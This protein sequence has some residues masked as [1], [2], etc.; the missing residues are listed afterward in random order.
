[1][2]RFITEHRDDGVTEAL[3]AVYDGQG[4]GVDPVLSALQAASVGDDG[5]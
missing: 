1:M 2:S 4:S 5:W 3:D